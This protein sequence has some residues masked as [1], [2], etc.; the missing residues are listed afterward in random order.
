MQHGDEAVER[1]AQALLRLHSPVPSAR[2]GERIAEALALAVDSDLALHVA[3]D[4]ALNHAQASVWPRGVRLPPV[5]ASVIER[6]RALNPLVH[7]LAA[8]R[9]LRAWRLAD[10]GGEAP[11]WGSLPVRYQMVMRLASPDG[12][13]HAAVLARGR[14]EFDDGERRRVELMWPHLVHL[15]RDARRA[16]RHGRVAAPGERGRAERGIVLL[17]DDLQVLLATEQARLWLG[18]YFGSQTAMGL[19]L[20]PVRPWLPPAVLDWVRRRV[21]GERL[22][23]R[24]PVIDR[25]PLVCQRGERCLV[26]DL[27]VDLGRGEHLLTLV[28]EALAAPAS[29]LGGLGLTAR[30][31]EVL[32]WVAQ[33]KT[34]REI[35]MILGASERTVQ[36]HLERVFQ[37]LGVE[38]RTA[39]TLKAWQAARYAMLGTTG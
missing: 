6:E 13:L 33:G 10:V 2:A 5:D 29:A 28:E 15:L 19:A 27:V 4:P 16:V 8:D 18:E 12:R 7:W 35:G 39:A 32:S 3:V 34:N 24:E 14:A 36:K 25:D 21:D 17:D 37:K 26:V 20:P 23:M 1:L 9:S 22:A 11:P 38:S 31:T 30:E